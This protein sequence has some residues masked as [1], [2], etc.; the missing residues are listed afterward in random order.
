[1]KDHIVKHMELAQTNALAQARMS[2]NQLLTKTEQLL[3]WYV[4][5]QGRRNM[6]VETRDLMD[7]SKQLYQKLTRKWQTHLHSTL[8]KVGSRTSSHDTKQGV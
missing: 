7:T 4:Q 6:A 3:V 1:M 2:P 5:K 8:L